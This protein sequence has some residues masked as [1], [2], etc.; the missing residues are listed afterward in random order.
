MLKNTISF[1]SID[2]SGDLSESTVAELHG[3]LPK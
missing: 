3:L 1:E 2:G